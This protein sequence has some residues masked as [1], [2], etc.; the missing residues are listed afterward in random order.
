MVNFPEDKSSLIPRLTRVP[1][2]EV[3]RVCQS[4]VCHSEANLITAKLVSWGQHKTWERVWSFSQIELVYYIVTMSVGNSVDA[5]KCA[6]DDEVILEP[7]F[8]MPTYAQLSPREIPWPIS[9]S[10]IC[11]SDQTLSCFLFESL[12]LRDYRKASSSEWLKEILSI[13]DQY[14]LLGRAWASPT[15]AWLHYAR[16]CVSACLL[17]YL[18]RPL[19]VN[20]KWAHCIQIFH[21]DRYR[22]AC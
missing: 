17:A 2:N 3:K 20:Y 19:T 22:E 10:S 7:D 8:Q 12:A 14:I 21:E 5:N 1:R 4:M 11:D 16:M 9:T 6:I 13:L 18:D 15:L